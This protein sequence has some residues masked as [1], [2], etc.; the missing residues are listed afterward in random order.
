MVLRRRDIQLNEDG[1]RGLL[2]S[3]SLS[4]HLA[5]FPSPTVLGP[6]SPKTLF[7]CDHRASAM[8]RYG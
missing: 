7:R 2:F 6:V 5:R 8:V 4:I 1:P 3:S